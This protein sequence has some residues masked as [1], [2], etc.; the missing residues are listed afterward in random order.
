MSP[1]A[2]LAPACSAYQKF[3]VVLLA[4]LQFTVVLDFMGLFPLGAMLLQALALS[5][6]QFSLVVPAYAG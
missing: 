3:L 5:P 6:H 1:S 4:L 2:A